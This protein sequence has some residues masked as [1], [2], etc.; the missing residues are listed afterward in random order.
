MRDE[1]FILFMIL[2]L[3]RSVRRGVGQRLSN[4]KSTEILGELNELPSY[5]SYIGEGVSGRWLVAVSRAQKGRDKKESKAKAKE[6]SAMGRPA[7]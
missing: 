3:E 5:I 4:R 1:V 6:N 2:I 7:H